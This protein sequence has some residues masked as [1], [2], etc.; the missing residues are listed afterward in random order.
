[1]HYHFC[2][3]QF[4]SLHN[5]HSSDRKTP[6]TL[7]MY[8]QRLKEI[9]C[10]IY[11][12]IHTHTPEEVHVINLQ[13]SRSSSTENN[14][15]HPSYDAVLLHC[16]YLTISLFHC[17]PSGQKLRTPSRYSRARCSLNAHTTLFLDVTCDS[18]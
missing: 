3:Q 8:G 5:S 16:H 18:G 12:H 6:V 7:G 11:K 13:I 14:S 9:V 15:L 4:L 17:S 10:N 2:S 1:M